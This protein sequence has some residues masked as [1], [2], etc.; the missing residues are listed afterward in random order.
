MVPASSGAP[1]QGGSGEGVSASSNPVPSPGR[2]LRGQK[3]HAVAGESS[4]CPRG[5][6]AASLGDDVPMKMAR[7]VEPTAKSHAPVEE[8]EESLAPK[9]QRGRP[10]SHVWPSP[11][12][13]EYTVGCLGC[14]GR[15]YRHLVKCQQKRSELGFSASS[16]SQDAMGDTVMR[17]A[18]T[19]VE[20]AS[21][22]PP[23]AEPPPE[24]KVSADTDA[25]VLAAVHPYGHE[26]LVETSQMEFQS[27]VRDG[28]YFEEDTLVEGVNRE[29]DLMKSFPV[30]RG[31]PR[32]EA[33][34]KICSTRWCYRRK[35]PK[36]VRAR[37]VV[38][39]FA[40][41]LDANLYRPT[42]GLEVTRVLMA[43]A[44]AKALTILFGDIIIA[45][46]NTPMREGEPVYVEPPEGLYEHNDDVWCLRRAPNGLRDT[47][48]LFHEHCADVLTSRLEFTRSEAQPTLFVD[49][50][51]SVSIAVHVDD[52]IMV[53]SSSQ[54]Y[55]VVAEMKQ[56]FTTLPV[57]HRRTWAQDTCDTAT[58]FGSCR[59]FSMYL[60]C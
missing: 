38:R 46:M 33:T 42:P 58:P 21:P 19:P 18:P 54:L 32:A 25:M 17:D 52:L 20:E 11:G 12:S 2:W 31:V 59:Q 37:F 41:S 48:R 13:P 24:L 39:Q 15:S 1:L 34:G 55:D 23:P 7:A 5:E 35:G 40:N 8:H 22:P 3:H 28:F 53:S 51:R 49:L 10:A 9:R 14:D 36:K 6:Q 26:E 47:S 57:Q 44:L 4:Q 60:A 16:S 50:A 27:V 56:H 29:L 30:Y 45:F 43:M